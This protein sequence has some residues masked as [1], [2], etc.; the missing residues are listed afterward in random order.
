M[1]HELISYHD[2]S[3]IL[4]R[5][6][7]L[8]KNKLYFWR[9]LDSIYVSRTY[10][11]WWFHRTS[12]PEQLSCKLLYHDLNESFITHQGVVSHTWSSCSLCETRILHMCGMTHTFLS[13]KP[14]CHDLSEW[15]Q[16]HEGVA[17]HI[18]AQLSGNPFCHDIN[19]AFNT[20]KEVT[21]HTRS[22]C[23]ICVTNSYH[24]M[25]SSDFESG[26]AI[27]QTTLFF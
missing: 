14:L 23:S 15:F 16:T 27:L 8:A 13:C 19:G 21:S 1:C 6:S 18:L 3:R 7:Y 24:I 5:S 26:A 22:G 9:S 2:I 4:I 25:I 10:I 20:H 11:I 12:N 17:S